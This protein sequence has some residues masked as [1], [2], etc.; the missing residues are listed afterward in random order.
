[1]LF[2]VRD[3][4]FLLLISGVVCNDEASVRVTDEDFGNEASEIVLTPTLAPSQ[5]VETTS[6]SPKVTYETPTLN[7]LP[8]SSL[9]P[10]AEGVESVNSVPPSFITTGG[11]STEGYQDPSAPALPRTDKEGLVTTNNPFPFLT[12]LTTPLVTLNGANY[13]VKVGPLTELGT[14]PS[15]GLSGSSSVTDTSKSTDATTEELI[16][17]TETELPQRITTSGINADVTSLPNLTTLSVTNLVDE[18]GRESTGITPSP[19]GSIVTGAITHG[20]ADEATFP[21]NGI[22]ASTFAGSENPGGSTVGQSTTVATLSTETNLNDISTT[23]SSQ[24]NYQ[25]NAPLDEELSQNDRAFTTQTDILLGQSSSPTPSNFNSISTLGAEDSQTTQFLTTKDDTAEE[26]TQSFSFAHFESS[27]ATHFDSLD[28]IISSLNPVDKMDS[29]GSTMP[30]IHLNTEDHFLTTSKVTTIVK[31]TFSTEEYNEKMDG[32]T[33]DR[34]Y[35]TEMPLMDSILSTLQQSEKVLSTFG[36]PMKSD[37]VISLDSSGPASAPTVDSSFTSNEPLTPVTEIVTAS[38][39][40]SS[41]ATEQR[42]DLVRKETSSQP[43]KATDPIL[44]LSSSTSTKGPKDSISTSADITEAPTES[45]Y[46]ESSKPA[47]VT[48]SLFA[49]QSSVDLILTTKEST[50]SLNELSSL[51]TPAGFIFQTTEESRK[52]T[53]NVLTDTTSYTPDSFG[54]LPKGTQPLDL[55]TST[56]SENESQMES[57]ENYVWTTVQP[58]VPSSFSAH[59]GDWWT[60]APSVQKDIV[61]SPAFEV[62]SK[63]SQ[64]TFT[65]TYSEISETSTSIPTTVNV[66]PLP[67][68]SLI[69][70]V[71]QTGGQYVTVTHGNNEGLSSALPSQKATER[72]ITSLLSDVET[73]LS[74]PPTEVHTLTT[75]KVLED[76]TTHTA[77]VETDA[78]STKSSENIVPPL[79]STKRSTDY[80]TESVT[81]QSKGTS[82]PEATSSQQ[83]PKDAEQGVVT[84]ATAL[85][86]GLIFLFLLVLFCILSVALVAGWA[87]CRGRES[88]RPKVS[89]IRVER[90]LATE[91][92][93]SWSKGRSTQAWLNSQPRATLNTHSPAS[94]SSRPPAPQ[95]SSPTR[96]TVPS[97]QCGCKRR[98]LFGE[99][100]SL[101]MIHGNPSMKHDRETVRALKIISLSEESDGGETDTVLLA[102]L[103]RRRASGA[104]NATGEENIESEV[105]MEAKGTSE[106]LFID[107]A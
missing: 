98:H 36:D 12:T 11:L 106:W 25:S 74:V 20:E 3:Y 57:N 19:T 101:C 83:K 28:S 86:M 45:P 71:D 54:T 52:S 79:I 17:T 72:T 88:R 77:K 63:S 7:N 53:I 5:P 60:T 81:F 29:L 59:S 21:Q 37:E 91:L 44:T 99:L 6:F 94:P 95:S 56:P 46:S 13:T 69:S 16:Q 30:S 75:A 48:S 14:D 9:A 31:E 104:S 85:S 47:Q 102:E 24:A 76:S 107:E 22:S 103:G 66:D 73:E 100:N 64:S 39:Y 84:I 67:T 96:P 70:T 15:N 2:A 50:H 68:T 26:T 33:V 80:F 62:A 4:A 105:G 1:M 89:L 32:T 49:S 90:G 97:F 35:T 58:S 34:T 40:L 18:N 43:T 41:M 93:D 61:T 38:S 8:A 87:Q 65:T 78:I 55:D 23:F 51:T 42:T 10:P 82:R 27:V 92:A